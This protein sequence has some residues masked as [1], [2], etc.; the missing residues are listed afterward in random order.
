MLT[1]PHSSAIMTTPLFVD[2]FSQNYPLKNYLI[3]RNSTPQAELGLYSK[4]VFC[5]EKRVYIQ[6][7]GRLL[8]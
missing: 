3:E 8:Q 5:K 1:R 7:Y 2:K 6:R 4:Y